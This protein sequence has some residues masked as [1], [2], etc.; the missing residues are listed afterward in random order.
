MKRKNGPHTHRIHRQHKQTSNRRLADKYY[1]VGEHETVT[2]IRLTQYDENSLVTHEVKTNES[3][4]SKL[5]DDTYINWFQVSG[6]TDSEAIT[7][8]VKDCGLHNLDA[9]DILTPQH[10]IKIEEYQGRLLIILNSCYYNENLELHSEH[11]SIV[12]SGHVIISFTESNNPVFDNVMQAL[13]S[14]MLNIRKKGSGMLL[15]FLLNTLTATLA[16]TASKVEDILEDIEETLL[17]VNNN[18]ENVG[19]LIQQRRKDY[20]TIRKNSQP[21]KEQFPKLLRME[22]G[23]IPQEMIPVYNDIYDQ[24]QFS[25]QTS[26]SCREIISSLVD[27][28]ISNN[29][30]RMN[31]IMKRLTVVATLFIP[32]TFLAGIWGM[33]F[34]NMPELGWKHGYLFA[35]GIML[36]T[37]I[38]TWLFL[39]KKDW[40]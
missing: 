17:D 37:A 39:K 12:V 5:T 40:Y 4:F 33:N 35:W 15:A 28:Y 29:D 19:A 31:A 9:K 11:I 21:L 13:K 24:I 1:Y 23:I 27:L 36:L 8:I 32:L 25:V 30:L 18:Q 14:N 20:M 3:S 38:L 10:I 22:N 7:R 26:E 16:E 34:T 6:L 2:S